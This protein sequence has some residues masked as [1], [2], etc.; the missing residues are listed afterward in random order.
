M[1]EMKDQGLPEPKFIQEL[2][3]R[4]IIYRYTPKLPP[5]YPSSYP[6]VTEQPTMQDIIS[7]TTAVK[8]LIKVLEGAMS[9]EELQE[10]LQLKDRE[11]FRSSYINEALHGGWIEMTEAEP[12][13]PNQKYR[14]TE[15]GLQIKEEWKK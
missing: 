12:N 9:R 13:H 11:Y 14:L 1:M 4:T 8:N 5:S 7:L 15:K 2:D 10:A 3:F 6:Q